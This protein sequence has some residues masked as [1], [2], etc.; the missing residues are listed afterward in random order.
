MR[1]AQWCLKH[2][3]RTSVIAVV[4]LF[5]TLFGLTPLLPTGF[6]PPDDLSQTQ[7]VLTLPPGSTFGQTL[8][9]V[10]QA[11]AI[12]GK[13]PHVKTI[14][15]TIGGGASGA[16]PFAPQGAA[17]VRKG[18]LTINLTPRGERRGVNKQAVEAGFRRE[19]EVI[20]GARIRVG[21]GGNSE[22]Y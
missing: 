6:I 2:R 9:L 4:F 21:L 14:Y 22:K 16:D 20:A 3:V 8:A 11:E 10:K 18:T 7:V 19:L 12:V 17:E 15:T 1:L 5:G 13:N